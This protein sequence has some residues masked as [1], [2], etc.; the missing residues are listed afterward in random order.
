V[1]DLGHLEIEFTIEDP[2]TYSK[3]WVIKRVADLDI[4]DEIGEYV[5][6]D[7][8]APTWLANREDVY[9]SAALYSAT[10]LAQARSAS[11]LL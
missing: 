4:N 10:S 5:C 6:I 8:D 1:V 7:R 11:A 9:T 2:L 3:P